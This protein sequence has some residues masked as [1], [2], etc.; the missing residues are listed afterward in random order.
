MS[1]SQE[2]LTSDDMDIDMTDK[3]GFHLSYR[4]PVYFFANFVFVRCVRMSINMAEAL[5]SVKEN[6]SP[7]VRG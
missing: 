1:A 2:S 4:I 6:L 7:L 5:D 3:V